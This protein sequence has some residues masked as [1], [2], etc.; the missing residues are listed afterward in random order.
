MIVNYLAHLN[1]NRLSVVMATRHLTAAGV[2]LGTI[3]GQG[4][5]LSLS[6]LVPAVGKKRI[7]KKTEK[8][9]RGLRI[10]RLALNESLSAIDI[11]TCGVRKC[12]GGVP[13]SLDRI[14]SC[15]AGAKSNEFDERERNFGRCQ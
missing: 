11:S 12:I 15:K 4:L 3:G 2:L 7:V 10:I 13:F 5:N 6:A 1:W 9:K 14:E 8:F